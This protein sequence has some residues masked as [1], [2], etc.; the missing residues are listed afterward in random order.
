MLIYNYKKEFIGIDTKDLKV[1]G[2]E[3][4]AQLRAEAADFA[5]LFVKTPGFVHN[6]QHV[7]WIDYITC[8][9][10]TEKPKVMIN[11]NGSLFKADIAIQTAYLADAPSEE[12]YIVNL[13]HLRVLTDQEKS[14]VSTDL[15]EKPAPKSAAEEPVSFTA[16]AAEASPQTKPTSEILEDEYDSAAH[17]TPLDVGDLSVDGVVDDSMDLH[18]ELTEKAEPTSEPSAPLDIPESIDMEEISEESFDEPKAAPKAKPTPKPSPAPTMEMPKN[19]ELQKLLESD[20]VYDPKIASDELGLPLDLIEEFIEDFIN[21]A[22]EFKPGLYEAL[23]EGDID[24]VKI[25][26]HKLKGVAANLRIEDALEVLTTINTTSDLNI[27]KNN[28]DAFYMII[29]KLAGED[30]DAVNEPQEEDEDELLLDLKDEPEEE[31]TLTEQVEEK[32]E[33]KNEEHEEI[34]IADDD[35]PEQIDLP[36]FADDNFI[37]PE[38]IESTEEPTLELQEPESIEE[39]PNLEEEPEV[40]QE[41]EQTPSRSAKKYSKE[42]IASELGLDLES[43]HELVEDFHSEA[44]EIIH[45]MKTALQNSDLELVQQQARQLKG[46]SDN[47]R[48]DDF[49]DELKALAESENVDSAASKVSHI[50]ELLEKISI[51]D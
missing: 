28:L 11:V 2:L 38:Q 22:K 20:Y 48:L 27:I 34:T 40:P 32:L 14:G 3:N 42:S 6:F 31:L 25:L 37:A 44:N 46:M 10:S 45:T 51:E 18:P 15:Q 35:V 23:D 29:S 26:S 7:H 30:L 24:N 1:L 43:V 8:A 12:A 21:Q 39:T 47:I 19:K 41:E 36:E 50:E 4:L 9:D 5:D 49:S 17:E 16:P 33:E 13:N